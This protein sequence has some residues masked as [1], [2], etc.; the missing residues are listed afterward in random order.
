MT[1]SCSAQAASDQELAQALG[2]YPGRVCQ[3]GVVGKSRIVQLDP[4]REVAVAGPLR[5]HV[6]AVGAGLDEEDARARRCRR[7]D[8]EEV[9]PGPARDQCLHPV[10]GPALVGAFGRR[11]G[12]RRQGLA[13][14][15]NRRGEQ[16]R[17]RGGAR[18]PGPLLARRTLLGDETADGAVRDEGD[19][20]NGAP[21]LHQDPAELDQAEAGAVVLLGEGKA[22][23]A[24]RTQLGPQ[25]GVEPV[26]VCLDLLHPLV[27]GAVLEDAGGQV[28]RLVLL[29][30]EREVH[31]SL[32]QSFQRRAA[33]SPRPT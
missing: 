20:G 30:G 7:G 31:G 18:Q 3:H 2:R 19:G 29:R 1:P 25:L 8:Q 23:Q 11:Q 4:R 6:H 32:S 16:S 21:D 12:M 9:S 10:Q 26:A 33:G 5:Q 17:T 13:I 27:G 15:G 14:L 22:E 24:R 28:G